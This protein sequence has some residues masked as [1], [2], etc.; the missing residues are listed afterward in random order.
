MKNIKLLT[1]AVVLMLAAVVA[2]GSFNASVTSA[3][4]VHAPA[5]K[6]SCPYGPHPGDKG[7]WT[8]KTK[9]VNAKIFFE[10]KCI[11]GHKWFTKTAS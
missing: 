7:I 3:S 10:Q 11:Q 8:G 5:A 2:S 9:T 1:V 4:D 6:A